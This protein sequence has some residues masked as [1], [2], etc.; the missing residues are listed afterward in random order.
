MDAY[1]ACLMLRH[2]FADDETDWLVGPLHTVRLTTTPENIHIIAP[3]QPITDTD[4]TLQ[5][6]LNQEPELAASDDSEDEDYDPD[7]P[8]SPPHHHDNPAVPPQ[9]HD[10]YMGQFQSMGQQLGTLNT[11]YNNLYQNYTT[12]NTNYD[13]LNTHYHN[14]NN[15]YTNLNTTVHNLGQRMDNHETNFGH[16]QQNFTSFHNEYNTHQNRQS[17][18]YANIE[19]LLTGI[20]GWAITQPGYPHPPPPPEN[21]H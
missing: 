2:R 1:K 19:R 6:Q 14:L 20:H 21:D 10:Q 9:Y 16:L 12:L 5:Q 17:A 18:Q 11:N 15:N 3:R 4:W 8:G 13:N 7:G